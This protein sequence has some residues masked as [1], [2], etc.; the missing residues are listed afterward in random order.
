[1]KE[2]PEPNGVCD[3]KDADRYLDGVVTIVAVICF[4]VLAVL[5]EWLEVNR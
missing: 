1:M 3:W 5:M 4:V 2:E